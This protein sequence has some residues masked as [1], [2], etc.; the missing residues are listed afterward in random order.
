MPQPLRKLASEDP[1]RATVPFN[2]LTGR[3]G[4]TALAVMFV[5]SAHLTVLGADPDTRP[6]LR[7]TLMSLA[8]AT[9]ECATTQHQTV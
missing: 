7:P 6:D 9:S 4:T 3:H 2:R 5:G 8:D 1:A